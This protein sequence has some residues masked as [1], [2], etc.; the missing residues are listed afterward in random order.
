MRGVG[1]QKQV[2]AAA[3][4]RASETLEN[5][6]EQV[7]FLGRRCLPGLT[8]RGWLFL[9]VVCQR[10][11][12]DVGCM[13]STSKCPSQTLAQGVG[14]SKSTQMSKCLLHGWASQ[15]PLW[16][17]CSAEPKP[18]APLARVP[19]ILVHGSC[20]VREGT[21]ASFEL[22]CVSRPLSSERDQLSV[23]SALQATKG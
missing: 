22:V 16:A 15:D 14:H 1:R 4:E 10:A 8:P 3:G 13:N 17:P 12:F 19:S 23:K 2:V 6:P 5:C 20:P 18:P 7:G 11:S 9:D 21:A